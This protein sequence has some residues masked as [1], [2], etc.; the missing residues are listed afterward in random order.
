M[1]KYLAQVKFN[2]EGAKGMIEEGGSGR[3]AAVEKA[4]KA[5]G[6]SLEAYYFAFGEVDAYVI[7]DLPDGAAAIAA[8]LVG[9]AAGTQSVTYIP[10]HHARGTRRG[11][12]A[13]ARGRGVL[14][15]A[16]A[17]GDFRQTCQVSEE[18]TGLLVAS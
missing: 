9:N 16:G 6:G 1:P 10:P 17:V 5:L 7:F 4:A 13:R 15:A 8:S 18:S 11:R 3:R 12:P 2:E 14:S